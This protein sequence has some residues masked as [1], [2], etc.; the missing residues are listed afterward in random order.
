MYRKKIIRIL[1]ENFEK[2]EIDEDQKPE[3]PVLTIKTS[4]PVYPILQIRIE[5]AASWYGG[6]CQIK[7]EELKRGKNENRSKS[8]S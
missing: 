3:V 8:P 7:F 1:K 4:G 6:P 2:F 5:R